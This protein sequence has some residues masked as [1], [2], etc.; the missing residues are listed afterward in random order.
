LIS[1]FYSLIELYIQ[2]TTWINL[3]QVQLK[4]PHFEGP[5]DKESFKNEI[6]Q[7]LRAIKQRYRRT[8]NKQIDKGVE[9]EDN[10]DN[11]DGE[12][13]KDVT[14]SEEKESDYSECNS[15]Y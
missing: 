14:E 1:A 8:I 5:V 9:E 3:F 15:E 7:V 6:L 10:E 2:K 13:D 12:Q 11:N 4:N